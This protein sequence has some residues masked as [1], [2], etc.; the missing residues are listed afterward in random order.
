MLK[1]IFKLIA[2]VALALSVLTAANAA[3]KLIPVSGQIYVNQGSGFLIATAPATLKTGDRIMV[4]A[5]SSAI[6]A[7]S[8]GC[9][10]P[11]TAG[12]VV[13][14]SSQSPCAFKAN[15]DS[16]GGIEPAVIG[17]LT[18]AFLAYIF[19]DGLK[20]DSSP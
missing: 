16:V 2:P 15:R 10:V 7:Y 6:L 3:P 11:L 13:T 5:K 4:Q 8:N 17:V 20:D 14:I 9:S 12:K 1:T 19:Y 18:A